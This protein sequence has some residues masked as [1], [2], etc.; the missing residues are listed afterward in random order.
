MTTTRFVQAPSVLTRELES[1]VLV[2]A[3][4]SDGVHSLTGAGTE[5]WRL[6]ATPVTLEELLE[7]LSVRFA[8]PQADI[9]EDVRRILDA[10]VAAHLVESRAA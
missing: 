8:I 7:Q 3:R 10:L 5:I 9:G 2:R 4:G 1:A 6:L